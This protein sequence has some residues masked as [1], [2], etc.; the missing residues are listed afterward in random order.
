MTSRFVY[1]D[2]PAV[3]DPRAALAPDAQLVHETRGSNLLTRI[4]I[5]KG[6]VEAGFRAAD[7]VLEGE[8]ATT[9]QEHAFLGL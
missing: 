7:I 3:T 1:E 8:F 6:D 2:L 4:P 9:W 5:R